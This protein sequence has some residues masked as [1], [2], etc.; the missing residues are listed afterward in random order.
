MCLGVQLPYNGAH[1]IIIASIFTSIHSESPKLLLLHPE[2]TSFI[3]QGLTHTQTVTA[4]NQHINFKSRS[5]EGY[6]TEGTGEIRCSDET[7]CS[8]DCTNVKKKPLLKPFVLSKKGKGSLMLHAALL[9]SLNHNTV[10]SR[11]RKG[12][13][14]EKNFL[15]N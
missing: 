2:F 13:P 9:T 1:F 8:Q 11:A 5:Q 10:L 7:F 6:K 12:G 15:R 14:T 3:K 4:I